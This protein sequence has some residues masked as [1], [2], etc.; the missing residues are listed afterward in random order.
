MEFSV[1][2]GPQVCKEWDSAAQWRAA[3]R[4]EACAG[5]RL[6]TSFQHAAHHELAETESIVASRHSIELLGSKHRLSKQGADLAEGRKGLAHDLVLVGDAGGQPGVPR[7]Q[8]EEG[9]ADPGGVAASLQGSLQNQ[10][11]PIRP[12]IRHPATPHTWRRA[13]LLVACSNAC[14]QTLSPLT[15]T[16]DVMRCIQ[17]LVQRYRRGC[18][19]RCRACCQNLS[20]STETSDAM[21]LTSSAE[22]LKWC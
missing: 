6:C 9:A 4:Q 17:A 13:G 19:D 16:S 21:D 10:A 22:M 15:G 8:R 7:A 12:R 1:L 20:P 5:R 3:C 2:G 11:S 18:Q 14:C